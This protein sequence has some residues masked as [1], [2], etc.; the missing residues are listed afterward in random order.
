MFEIL[1]ILNT[2]LLAALGRGPAQAERMS[3]GGEE[4][5]VDVSDT[6]DRS[7]AGL[8]VTT[9]FL[10]RATGVATP[11]GVEL[12]VDCLL[13]PPTSPKKLGH[14][15]D[16]FKGCGVA[17]F[18]T[19][20]DDLRAEMA[21]LATAPNGTFGLAW[22]PRRSEKSRAGTS[23]FIIIW[24]AGVDCS[25]ASAGGAKDGGSAS[26]AY[27]SRSTTLAR[28]SGVVKAGFAGDT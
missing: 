9:S 6:P 18:E 3:S 25:R 10:L 15:S 14:G 21:T 20:G 17:F 24:R 27:G 7:S 28:W 2:M 19:A 5:L 13:L 23:F 8:G 16:A 22:P 26:L 1:K 12:D 11:A 4:A